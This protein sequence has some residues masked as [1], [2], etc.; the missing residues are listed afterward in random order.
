[1]MR[2]GVASG[3]RAFSIVAIGMLF[4]FL[5]IEPTAAASRSTRRHREE[6]PA[7]QPCSKPAV[8]CF[9]WCKEDYSPCDPPS[10]KLAD[11]RCSQKL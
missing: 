1:M 4:A 2:D 6:P 7:S 9:A 5:Q 8:M 10:F 11:K 3:T